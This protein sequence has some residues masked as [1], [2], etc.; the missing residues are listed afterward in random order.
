MRTT[1]TEHLEPG[2]YEFRVKGHID[3]R[4]ASWFEGLA[5]RHEHD[6]TTTLRGAVTDQ[7]AMHGVISKFRDLGMTLISVMPV[8]EVDPEAD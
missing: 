1:P 7:A 6:E 3:S 5:L 4:W 8:N 2:L